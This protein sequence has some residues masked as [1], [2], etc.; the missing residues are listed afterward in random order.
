MLSRLFLALY[1]LL[2]KGARPFLRRHRRL[3]DSFARR[4]VPP[5]WGTGAP[6]PYTYWIQ[7]ASGGEAFLARRLVFAL[8]A[9]HEKDDAAPARILCTTCT[10]Q[11]ME[12]LEALRRDCRADHPGLDL[13][14]DFFPL[15]E[16]RLME[17]ALARVRPG[18]VALLETELWPGL[19][20]AC[21]AAG[22][23]FVVLN[24]RMRDKSFKSYRLLR[25]F[26]KKHPPARILA[27]GDDDA[28][29]F[30]ALFGEDR[31]GRMPNMKFE[32][33]AGPAGEPYSAGPA[34]PAVTD[35]APFMLL[36][37]VRREEEALLL[38]VL[39]D[40][41]RA[42][43]KFSGASLVIAP[44]HM[45]RVPFW[46]DA[47]EKAGM[48]AILRSGLGEAPSLPS[49]RII[50]WDR[51]GELDALYRVAGAVFVGGSL[52]PL[53]G[54]N[55]LEP[56]AAGAATCIGPSWGN[57]AWAGECVSRGFARRV[58]DAVELAAVLPSFLAGDHRRERRDAF[59]AFIA[60]EQGGS[61]QAAELLRQTA[62]PRLSPGG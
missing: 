61:R 24:A 51:F 32:G 13:A 27:M 6:S 5:D 28:A 33:L 20:A 26:W 25:F 46:R 10:R 43:G 48:P 31:V 41:L 22:T 38:P 18:A 3:A 11:G 57:F 12:V 8:A 35:A 49:S 47:L 17:K 53:G 34:G 59:A 40:M 4:L 15:D 1:A 19:M 30:A 9:A 7:A 36:A 62:A 21:T 14:V 29:R 2:W 54:Q 37:S 42:A 55:F 60:G 39:G 23:P 16:P 52:A 56:L 45:E 58:K 50:L 44:R